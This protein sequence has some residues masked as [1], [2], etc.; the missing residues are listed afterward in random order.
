LTLVVAVKPYL[1]VAVI[2]TVTPIAA[3]GAPDVDPCQIPF[4]ESAKEIV[5]G[6]GICTLFAVV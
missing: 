1:S 2:T 5:T 4:P 6:F 3:V